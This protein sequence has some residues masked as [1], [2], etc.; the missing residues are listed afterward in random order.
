MTM[1]IGRPGTSGG[2][3]GVLLGKYLLDVPL[4]AGGMAEVFRA[5]TQ[6]VEGFQRPV[7]IKRILPDASRNP[8]FAEMFIA[9]AK[10]SSRLAHPNIVSVLDF[11]RDQDGRLYLVMELVE[12]RDLGEVLAASPSRLPCSVIIYTITEVLRGLGY[13]HDLPSVGSS[14]GAGVRGLIHRDISPHNVLCAWNGAVKVSDFGIAKARAATAASASLVIKGKPAYMSPE[15]I[16]GVPLDGRSDLFAVGVMLWQMLTG[17]YL[18]AL[19]TTTETLARVLFAPV[20]RPSSLAPDVP[21]DLEAVAMRLL[22]R[23]RA[24]RY[25]TA[26]DALDDLLRCA[27]AP[28]DGRRELEHVLVERFPSKAPVRN[29]SSSRVDA[30]GRRRPSSIPPGLPPVPGACGTLPLPRPLAGPTG[31]TRTIMP[32]VDEGPG[33]GLGEA[34]GAGLRPG[35][36]ARANSWPRGRRIAAAVAGVA[37][38]AA[39]MIGVLIAS[40][41]GRSAA[42]FGPGDAR[43]AGVDAAVDAA[44]VTIVLGADAREP[45]AA[46]PASDAARPARRGSRRT[47]APRP[48]AA[49]G[50]SIHEIELEPPR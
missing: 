41:S 46:A 22:E 42:A 18:F 39:A 47:A 17:Q 28:R 32:R 48:G 15:Q 26:E 25:A 38:V 12:G 50:G 24:Q 14:V 23:D 1:I 5:H 2:G 6:G 3:D 30:S 33:A 45:D 34:L 8:A 31:A 49:R 20:P 16:N 10:L 11:D 40:A 44:I 19:G 35:P 27:D 9:E 37:L 4:G 13:A 29:G 43:D 36:L 7:A 21:G